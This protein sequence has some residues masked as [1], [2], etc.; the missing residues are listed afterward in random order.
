MANTVDMTETPVWKS[1]RLHSILLACI[2]FINLSDLSDGDAQSI[3]SDMSRV[4]WR[5]QKRNFRKV[6]DTYITLG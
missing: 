5:K 1:A 4:L 6:N 2:A 3:E